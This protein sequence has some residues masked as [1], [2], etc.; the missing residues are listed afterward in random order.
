MSIHVSNCK[1][2]CRALSLSVH[3]AYLFHL[4][5][6]V[7]KNMCRTSSLSAH[8]IYHLC[9]YC[10]S[11]VVHTWFPSTH[12]TSNCLVYVYLISPLHLVECLFTI[13]KLFFLFPDFDKH[14]WYPWPIDSI[15][16]GIWFVAIH[17]GFFRFS[18]SRRFLNHWWLFHISIINWLSFIKF[19]FSIVE[20]LP[21]S[22]SS[23]VWTIFK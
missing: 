2:M 15:G 11:V 6:N 4:Y 19:R 1:T 20:F 3:E 7:C 13:Q 17:V 14:P 9:L 5:V 23:V 18:R 10:Q 16:E 12:S 21:F 8:V 22:F